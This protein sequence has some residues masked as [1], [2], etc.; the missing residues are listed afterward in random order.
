MHGSLHFHE[1]ELTHASGRHATTAEKHQPNYETGAE[2]IQT[3]TL[4]W[5]VDRALFIRQGNVEI[6]TR[7]SL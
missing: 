6:F 2:K 5:G 3:A 7:M 4:Q 1:Y